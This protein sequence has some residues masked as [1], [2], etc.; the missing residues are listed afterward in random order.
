MKNSADTTL[1]SDV[2]ARY[3]AATDERI[4]EVLRDCDREDLNELHYFLGPGILATLRMWEEGSALA[5]Y[6]RES[7]VI[8]L[9][10]MTADVLHA[11]WAELRR[12]A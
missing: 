3:I 6:C 2:V 9:T 4:L 5:A 10:E 1:L 12:L 7:G 11:V 8:P